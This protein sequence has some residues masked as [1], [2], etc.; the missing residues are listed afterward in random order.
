MLCSCIIFLF[1][2]IFFHNNIII[3]VDG[4]SMS[5]VLENKQLVLA[6]KNCSGINYSDIIIVKASDKKKLIKRVAAL[7]G[8]TV[9]SL[10]GKL[11]IND[12]VMNNYDYET[13]NVKYTLSDEEVFILGDNYNDSI[14]SRVFGPV[15]KED[16]V[17]VI[18]K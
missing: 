16:I 17:A 8:D 3:Y 11:I 15:Y 7:S 9:G 4:N 13:D 12:I 2:L 14:D 10:N 5:P 1:F 18:R 6:S